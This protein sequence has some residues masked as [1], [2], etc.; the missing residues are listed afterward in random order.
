MIALISGR[1]AIES[2]IWLIVIGIV[3]WLLFWLLDYAKL[4]Q[5][6]AKVGSII[7]AVAA[8]V[9]L[10]NFLFTLAGKPLIQ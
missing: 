2:L 7:L 10:I 3:F 6:F 9:V 4:P 5:P 1:A 8:V